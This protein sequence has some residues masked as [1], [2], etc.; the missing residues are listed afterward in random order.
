MFWISCHI[1]VAAI[2]VVGPMPLSVAT[3]YVL[4]PLFFV[5][6]DATSAYYENGFP[7]RPLPPERIEV[8]V[9]PLLNSFYTEMQILIPA[10]PDFT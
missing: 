5:P 9:I 2:Y 3:I 1:C 4:G 7:Q 8:V 10:Q 6:A